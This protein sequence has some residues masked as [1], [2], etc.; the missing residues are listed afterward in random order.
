VLDVKA[1]SKTEKLRLLETLWADLTADDSQVPSPAWHREALEETRQRHER[2]E[3]IFSDW[4][5]AKARL[6]ATVA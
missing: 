6:R 1:L 2:G 4:T 3:V 5:E